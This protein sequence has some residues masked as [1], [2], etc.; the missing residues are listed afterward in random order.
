MR[1]LERVQVRREGEEERRRGVVG[2]ERGVRGKGEGGAWV[3]RKT[4][5]VGWERC[6]CGGTVRRGVER[7]KEGRRAW[8]CVGCEGV[9]VQG[10]EG[11][12]GSGKGNVNGRAWRAW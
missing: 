5:W 3:V 12:D 2:V 9:V 10:Q 11:R 8:R 4:V 1:G 6:W 7:E